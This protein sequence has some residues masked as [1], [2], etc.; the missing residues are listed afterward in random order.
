VLQLVVGG[1]ASQRAAALV[2]QRGIDF[3]PDE[4]YLETMRVAGAEEALLAALRTAGEA[5]TGEI[6]VITSPNAEVYLDGELKGRANAQGELAL[7]AKLGAHALKVSLARKKDFEQSVTLAGG[8]AAKIEAR[9]EDL[10]GSIRVRT[11]AGAN[12]LLD[13]SA[14]GS[15]D[16]GGELVLAEVSSGAHEV[17]VSARGKRDYRQTVTVLAGQESRMEARLEDAGP[18]PGTVR[19]NP[20]DGLKYVWIPPGTFQMGCSPGD[21]E[22]QA[23]ENPSHRVTISKGLWLGQTEVTVGAYKRFARETGRG[24]PPELAFKKR[25][26]NP[27]WSNDQMPIANVTWN[28]AEAYCRWAGGRLPTEAEWEYAAR[29]G[30]TAARYGALDDVAWYANNSDRGTHEVS[31]KRPN[32]FNLYDML[33]NVWEWVSD[34]Y[35][36]YQ[37]SPARDP[38]GPGSGQFHV[39]RG[40]SWYFCG[41]ARVRVSGRYAG[42]TGGGG[43]DVGVR[44]GGEVFNP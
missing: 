42:D 31:Q 33:G 10:P 27:G 39:L 38:S 40:G 4:E 12:V 11:L 29:A 36:Y 13:N 19:E 41:P 5:A 34:W 2:K 28:D 44:C 17:R 14:R 26:L 25:A 18:A 22:C 32:A 9:L 7:K 21:S 35:D 20:K 24:M 6:V 43:G 30:S 3:M 16:A 8:Q 1:V 37:A 23:P 15:A